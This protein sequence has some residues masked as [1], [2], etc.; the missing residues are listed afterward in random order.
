MPSALYGFLFLSD[1][2]D[3]SYR[4]GSHALRWEHSAL[5][6]G[7]KPCHLTHTPSL[8]TVCISTLS[9]L[10][11]LTEVN[12][13]MHTS[14]T[15]W[16]KN[17]QITQAHRYLDTHALHIN[18][19]SFMWMCAIGVHISGACFTHSGQKW[20]PGPIRPLLQRVSLKLS[21]CISWQ[22]ALWSEAHTSATESQHD[23]YRSRQCRMKIKLNWNKPNW[24]RLK[25]QNSLQGNHTD[26]VKWRDK[27]FILSWSFTHF[28]LIQGPSGKK[29]VSQHA[30]GERQRNPPGWHTERGL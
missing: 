7:L 20:S 22:T 25:R 23:R 18:I 8:T 2:T 5:D 16:G 14:R 10:C 26:I 12:K 27:E 1:C 17:R 15:P 11:M 3:G 21:D 19:H 6:H 28:I 30:L 4:D 9:R 29:R 13:C 24:F